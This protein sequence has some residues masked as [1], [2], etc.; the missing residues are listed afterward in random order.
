[1]THTAPYTVANRKSHKTFDEMVHFC[2]TLQQLIDTEGNGTIILGVPFIYLHFC[3]E[4][5][6]DIPQV[7]IAAQTSS[8]FPTGA[9]T[10]EIHAS[11][12]ASLGIERAIIGHSERREY[13]FEKQDRVHY[14]LQ[15]A[16][17]A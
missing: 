14:Q 5:F 12:L 11:M 9:Y 15:A 1:M 7:Q 13:M 4:F 8:S 3:H 2:H 16:A 6:L 17:Q 10:G